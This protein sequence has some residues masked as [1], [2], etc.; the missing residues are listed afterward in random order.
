MD[1]VK[2]QKIPSFYTLMPSWE[3]PKNNAV[4]GTIMLRRLE[5]GVGGP[6]IFLE[7]SATGIT[8][9]PAWKNLDGSS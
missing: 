2:E 5:L 1:Y 9:I 6:I 7:F 3:G 4:E 8:D